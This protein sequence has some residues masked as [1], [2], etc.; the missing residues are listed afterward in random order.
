M[1][2]PLPNARS[3]NASSDPA[4]DGHRHQELD[5]VVEYALAALQKGGSRR[6][7]LI[8]ACR[9]RAQPIIM[10]TVA[11]G[12]GM[13]PIALKIGA[14]AELPRN[15]NRRASGNAKSIAIVAWPSTIAKPVKCRSEV[16]RRIRRPTRRPSRRRSIA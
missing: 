5:R 12:A 11:M 4:T 9:K 1:M 16:G 15:G 8:D 2:V 6:D 3:R 14:D 10:T 7:A 13:L